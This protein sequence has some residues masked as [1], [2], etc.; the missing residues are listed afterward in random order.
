VMKMHSHLHSIAKVETKTK[1]AYIN[2]Q[3]AKGGCFAG[4][5]CQLLL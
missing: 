1:T 5:A 4:C 3:V 2:L